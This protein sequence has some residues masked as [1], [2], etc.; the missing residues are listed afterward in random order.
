MTLREYKLLMAQSGSN[1]EFADLTRGAVRKADKI[2]SVAQ[3]KADAIVAEAERKAAEILAQA[4]AQ[5]RALP[6]VPQQTQQ[7]G[8]ERTY[9]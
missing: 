6:Q 4:R 8:Y 5:T 3:K 7:G 2:V 9:A 1:Q